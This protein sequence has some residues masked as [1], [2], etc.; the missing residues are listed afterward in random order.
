MLDDAVAELCLLLA[1]MVTVSYGS[2]EN[3]SRGSMAQLSVDTDM[4]HGTQYQG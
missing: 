3:G 2:D 1:L 4:L